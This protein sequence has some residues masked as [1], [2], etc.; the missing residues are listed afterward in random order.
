MW[1]CESC[2]KKY[3]E[4]TSAIEVRFGYI[5][6]EEAAKSENQYMAFNTDASW[7]PLCNE[8]A[9]AYIRGEK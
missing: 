2:N 7:A 9:I 1:R 6:S 8:C 3:S 4:K 5:D